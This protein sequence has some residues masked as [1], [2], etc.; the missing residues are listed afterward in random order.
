MD[1]VSLEKSLSTQG[2]NGGDSAH[3]GQGL[4][5]RAGNGKKHCSQALPL[6]GARPAAVCTI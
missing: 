4:R 3:S 5:L 2:G 6:E 1:S